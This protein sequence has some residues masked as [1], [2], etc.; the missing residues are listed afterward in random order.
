MEK[1][2]HLI[3]AALKADQIVISR[4]EKVRSL[5]KA[6]CLSIRALQSI[7]WAN[8]EIEDE[9]VI[10][11]LEAGAKPEIVRALGHGSSKSR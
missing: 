8:P 10:S 2:A 4:D 7:L 1:D 5:F 6:A 3:E 11:W 9:Q